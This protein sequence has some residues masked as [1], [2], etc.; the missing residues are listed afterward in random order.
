MKRIGF[1]STFVM[2]L[3]LAFSASALAANWK[4][5]KQLTWYW[6]LQGTPKVEPVMATDIDGFDNGSAEVAKLHAAGQ[7]AICYIDVGTAENFRSDYASIPTK[8]EGAT[9]GWPGETWLNVTDLAGLE[10]VM[11][12]RFEMCQAAGYDAVEPDNMDGFENSTGFSISAAQQL[13]YNEWVASDVHSLGMAVFQKNDPEQASALQP[14][15]DGVIDEQCNEYSECGSFASY[16]N[17]GK[18]VLNAEYSGGSSFC[19]ADN[20]AGIMGALY[21]LNL[22]GSTYAPCFAASAQGP[23]VTGGGTST[24]TGTGTGTGTVT[25]T[26]TGTGTGTVT[27]PGTGTGTGT[28][29]GSGKSGSGSGK[30]GGK[31]SE[32]G[33]G[34]SGKGKSGKGTPR[35][36]HAKKGAARR[37]AE[38]RAAKHRLAL[39][40]WRYLFQ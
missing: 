37:A 19:A 8:D 30:S 2:A 14:Y 33:T 10:P 4:P 1:I 23:P 6:Q 40:R 38:R 20:A 24:G 29:S 18:P 35:K 25:G 13:A 9:N 5:P 39:R 27:G 15:F 22:D 17:A 28:G 7:R 21:S 36:G 16:L 3:A 11:H 32:S 34:K 31:S 26:G 12:K